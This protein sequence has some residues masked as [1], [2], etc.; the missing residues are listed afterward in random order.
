MTDVKTHIDAETLREWLETG[1]PVT[2]LD[3]RRNEDRAEWVIPGSIHLNAYDA[4]R[5]GHAGPLADYAFPPDQPIVTVC[6]AGGASQ[7]AAELLARRG[8][9]ARSLAGGM[10]A[11]SL[12]WNTA[13]VSLDDPS[14]QVIQVRRTGKGC[15][16][17]IVA[18][19]GEAAVI[20]PSLPADIYVDL[21]HREGW[22][23]RHVIETHIH[24][25]H[26]SRARSLAERTGAR[27]LLPDQQRVHFPFT[28]I[29]DGDEIR[30][31]LAAIVARGTPGHTTESTS[32]VLHDLAV[33]T[34]DTLF[35]KGIGRP[36]LHA[37]L[38]GARERARALYASLS[39]LAALRP[40]M[41][42]LPA[43]VS[44]PIPFDGRAISTT[45]RDVRAWLSEW[46]IS[47]PAFIERVVSRLPATPP[48]FARIVA[49]NESGEWPTGDPTDLEAGANRCAIS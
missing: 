10:K 7:T 40:E 3:I 44:E 43:H 46:L 9:N 26:L 22:Q 48:N 21:A 11:W 24:A 28:P 27:L 39:Q 25:D 4:L 34:G 1:R 29:H 38:A 16:S 33:F 5:Q 35:T 49:L 47:E 8:L 12:A 6:N 20:D 17:Y 42:V 30:I 14:I 36:D 13:V 41:V 18:A 19:D 32:Y 2:I 15:L 45:I 31:G 23:V 37:D